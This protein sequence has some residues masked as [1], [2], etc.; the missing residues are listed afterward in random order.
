[1]AIFYKI[2]VGDFLLIQW[3]LVSMP[4]FDWVP[5]KPSKNFCE[6][7]VLEN[8]PRKNWRLVGKGGSGGRKDNNKQSSTEGQF[9]DARDNVGSTLG[10]S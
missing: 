8:I 6:T 9:H 1:M 4:N 10:L 7:D 2:S 5:Q 3:L